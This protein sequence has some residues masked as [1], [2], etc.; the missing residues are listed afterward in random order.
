MPRWQ[1]PIA[2]I[3]TAV[4]LVQTLG[5]TTTDGV[6]HNF[7]EDTGGGPRGDDGEDKPVAVVVTNVDKPGELVRELRHLQLL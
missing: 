5:L 6:A 2:N 4:L 7:G 1:P 3:A